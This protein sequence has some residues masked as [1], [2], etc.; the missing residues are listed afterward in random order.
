MVKHNIFIGRMYKR[1]TV[2]HQILEKKSGN[3]QEDWIKGAHDILEELKFESD[4][5]SSIKK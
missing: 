4:Y 5:Q 3:R 1:N 2:K